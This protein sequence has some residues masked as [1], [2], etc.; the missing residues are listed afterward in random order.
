[1]VLRARIGLIAAISLLGLSPAPALAIA[2][3]QVDDFQDGTLQ[4]WSGNSAPTNIASGGPAGA[5]DRYLRISAS[6]APLGAFNKV[7]WSGNYSL[8][9]I[10]HI[11]IHLNNFG[12]NAVS[13]RIMLMTPGCD[14]G[15][16]ACTA[17]ASTTATNL[18]ASSGWVLA[19]FSVKE[20]D[21]TRVLGS[22][23][24][25][26]SFP[27]IERLL[28][29]HDSGA[30][31]PPGSPAIV[32]ATLGIDNVLPEPGGPLGLIVGAALLAA[33]PRSRRP[34]RT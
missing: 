19:S 3:N 4:N 7:Q 13:I 8:A 27:N 32:T 26:T 20:A 15:G 5:T 1:M 30:P 24:Y 22:S 11:D 9:A 21:L 12:P 29:R 17:W 14:F 18:A 25:A 6:S 34:R 33:T 23:S 16:T 2:P 10:D 31:S 28:I